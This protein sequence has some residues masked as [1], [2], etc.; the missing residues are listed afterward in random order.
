MR[1]IT[2]ALEVSVPEYDALWA[3]YRSVHEHAFGPIPEADL[4]RAEL[5]FKA[6]LGAGFSHRAFGID[7]SHMLAAVKKFAN[8]QMKLI[9]DKESLQ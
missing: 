8:F 5:C 1:S 7:F 6:G 2:R 4:S 3:E 9:S